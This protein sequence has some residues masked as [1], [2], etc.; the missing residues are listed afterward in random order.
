MQL[1]R[2][3][4]GESLWEDSHLVTRLYLPALALGTSQGG[5]FLPLPWAW[6]YLSASTLMIPIASSDPLPPTS[7]I[8]GRCNGS[9]WSGEQGCLSQSQDPKEGSRTQLTWGMDRQSSHSQAG[10]MI[11]TGLRDRQ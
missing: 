2:L 10:T 7:T 6:P 4:L 5:E 1:C 11:R 3:G 9:R 8:C